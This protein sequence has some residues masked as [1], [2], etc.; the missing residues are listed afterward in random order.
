MLHNSLIFKKKGLPFIKLGMDHIWDKRN[1]VIPITYVKLEPNII[2]DIDS[3]FYKNFNK[4]KIGFGKTNSSKIKK[5][6]IGQFLK[7]NLEPKRLLYEIIINKEYCKYSI[8]HSFKISDI[9]KKH[10][11]V[12]ILGISK[13]KGF[14]GVMKRYKFK[15]ASSSHGQHKNHRK[16]GSIG[17]ATTPGKVFKGKKM[18]G[19]MGNKHCT[20]MN[21]KIISI[22]ND[23]SIMQVKG[24]APG[25]HGSKLFI[26]TTI[27]NFSS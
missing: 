2:T 24:S 22:D 12:D 19:R 25:S 17:G 23:N 15:G 8:G 10:L 9:F 21:S 16:P 7:F 5:P 27:K 13:G 26:R 1:N 6:I 14:S 20:V 3:K 11:S 4:I 18:P